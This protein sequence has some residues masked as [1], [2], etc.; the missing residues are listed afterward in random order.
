MKFTP[1]AAYPGARD[2]HTRYEDGVM[3]KL[4][5]ALS[6]AFLLLG[7]KFTAPLRRGA[8]P[9]RW[10]AWNFHLGKANFTAPDRHDS[11]VT[12]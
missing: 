12:G 10:W 9:S 2:K 5:T 6:F 8:N 11:P 1:T 3:I 4:Y 7:T